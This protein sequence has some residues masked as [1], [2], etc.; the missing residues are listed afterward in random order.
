MTTNNAPITI[1]QTVTAAYPRLGQWVNRMRAERGTALPDWPEWCFLPFAGWYAVASDQYG[2]DRLNPQQAA[3]LSTLAA[4]GTWRYSQGIYRPDP[5]TLAAL[6]ASTLSGQLP[7]DVFMRLPEWCVYIETPGLAYM[8]TPTAGFWAHLEHDAN[9]GHAELRLLLNGEARLPIIIYLGAWSLTEAIARSFATSASNA[10][11]VG[12]PLVTPTD[13]PARMAAAIQP[14]LALLLYLCSDEPDI[15]YSRLPGRLP[16]R[17]KP[18]KTKR[19]WQLF[20]AT[21]PRV[22]EVG[23]EI[24]QQLRQAQVDTISVL[25]QQG[26]D[27]PTGRHVRAH[28]RRGHWH[29]YWTGPRSGSQRFIYHWIPP[30]LAGGRTGDPEAE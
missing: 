1:L 2:V 19:G 18:E 30:L 14:Y 28:I 13:L 20:P 21:A 22:Y 24:G 7:S 17:P 6:A 23:R 26:A 4:L 8:D 27:A 11:E 29:G 5:D 9:D 10:A 25:P 15:D 16:S 12:L 3:G